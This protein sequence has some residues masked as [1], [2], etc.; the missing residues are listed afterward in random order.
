MKGQKLE[1]Y[2]EFSLHPDGLEM[3]LE[4][5]NRELSTELKVPAFAMDFTL[6]VSFI[7]DIILERSL[8][9]KG[10]W[11]QKQKNELMKGKSNRRFRRCSGQITITDP[12]HVSGN[13]I[14]SLDN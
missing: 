5:C 12:P 8:G 13:K 10:L 3:I 4:I 7:D 6:P 9:S 1:Y 2:L 14:T 11:G